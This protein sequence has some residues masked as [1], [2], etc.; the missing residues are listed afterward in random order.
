MFVGSPNTRLKSE[1]EPTVTG[2]NAGPDCAVPTTP[3]AGPSGATVVTPV[4]ST[5]PEYTPG[6]ILIPL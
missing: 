1:K 5:S 6:I 3:T 4:R 2:T